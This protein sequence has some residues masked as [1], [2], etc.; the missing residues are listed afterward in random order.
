MVQGVLKTYIRNNDS[1][2][3]TSVSVFHFRVFILFISWRSTVSREG[4]NKDQVSW[5]PNL[6]GGINVYFHPNIILDPNGSSVCVRIFKVFNRGIRIFRTALFLSDRGSFEVKLD[7]REHKVSWTDEGE[8][9]V[10]SCTIIG[11]VRRTNGMGKKPNVHHGDAVRLE[12]AG[13]PVPVPDD[14]TDYTSVSNGTRLWKNRTVN[15]KVSVWSTSSVTQEVLDY[16]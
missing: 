15:K 4:K 12:E 7:C 13:V 3:G 8:P 6:W 10:V 1:A 2:S 11:T 5:D 14:S 16:I 9:I